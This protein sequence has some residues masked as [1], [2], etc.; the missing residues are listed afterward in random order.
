M[1]LR[2]HNHHTFCSRW[3]D[4]P[5]AI[6]YNMILRERYPQSLFITFRQKVGGV[7]RY[8]LR[9]EPLEIECEEC[10]K[11]FLQLQLNQRYCSRRHAD[12]VQH[13]RKYGGGHRTRGQMAE[14]ARERRRRAKDEG[15][16]TRCL[17]NERDGEGLVCSQCLFRLGKIGA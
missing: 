8:M 7:V 2:H 4:K 9:W 17:K 6:R 15:K 5:T 14:A 16:C 11:V 10:G 12:N 3:V 1:K 13:R